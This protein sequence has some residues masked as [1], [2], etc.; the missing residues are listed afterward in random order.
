MSEAQAVAGSY[1]SKTLKERHTLMAAAAQSGEVVE[2]FV[3]RYPKHRLYQMSERAP[4]RWTTGGALVLVT[5]YNF[6]S[7]KE[8]ADSEEAECVRVTIVRT[9]G[10]EWQVRPEQYWIAPR[11]MRRVD[12]EKFGIELDT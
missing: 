2:E 1:L 4:Y 9:A 10:G 6:E 11:H 7:I 12:E 5:D 8:S 3:T